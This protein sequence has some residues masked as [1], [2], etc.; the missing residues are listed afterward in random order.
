MI[1]FKGHAALQLTPASSSEKFHGIDPDYRCIGAA[2][3]RWWRI[4]GS[5]SRYLVIEV[6][7]RN[8]SSGLLHSITD[9]SAR[10]FVRLVVLTAIMMMGY[11]FILKQ[12]QRV[13]IV[14][15]NFS[16]VADRSKA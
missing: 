16:M 7:L 5:P 9:P 13:Q 4:L 2:L 15:H 6:F 11:L 8:I 10:P 1:D 3:W 12:S 14:Q